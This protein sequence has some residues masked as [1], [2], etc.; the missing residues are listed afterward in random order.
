MDIRKTDTY[1]TLFARFG[2][3]LNI[4]Q[5]AEFKGVD[6]RTVQN[7]IYLGRLEFPVYKEGAAWYADTRLVAEYVESRYH[8]SKEAASDGAA[9]RWR[10]A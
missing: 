2:L 7:Q 3:R 1:K 5:I 9:V 10:M 4:E 8:E 6:R